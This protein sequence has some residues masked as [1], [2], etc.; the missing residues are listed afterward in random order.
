MSEVGAQVE[1]REKAHRFLVQTDVGSAYLRYERPDERTIDLKHTVV[2]E[3]AEGRG[4]GSALARAAFDYA[5]AQGLRVVV[6]C[7]FVTQWV[8]RHPEVRDVLG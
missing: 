1:H 5:R 8:K 2:P 7:P 6:T 4:V 3:A